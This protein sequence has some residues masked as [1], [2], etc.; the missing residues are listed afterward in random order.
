M[1]EALVIVTREGVEAA[2]V[3]AIVLAY[4]RKTGRAPLARWVYGGL[5]VALALSIA[6]AWLLPRLVASRVVNE[7]LV[8]GWLLLAGGLCVITLVVWLVRTGKRM[9]AEIDAGLERLARADRRF[10]WGLALFVTLLLVREGLETVLFLTAISFNTEGLQRLFGALAGLALAI[11]FGVLVV[12]GAL[13]VDLR[14]F[15]LATTGI[16]CVLAVQL[17]VGAYHEFAEAGWLPANRASMAIVGPVVRYDS[18]LFAVAI[19]ITF[20]LTYRSAAPAPA[21]PAA[22]QAHPAERRLAASRSRAEQRA[23]RAAAIAALSVVAV[24]LTGFVSQ[25]RVPPRA[26]GE[27]LV[28]HEGEVRVPVAGAE[29]AAVRFYRATAAGRTVRFFVARRSTGEPVAC[30]DA[31]LICGD[32][33]YYP[34]AAGMTCR[35]C[36]APIN[37]A[38]LGIG[39]G[40]NPI[41]LPSAARGGELV[42]DEAALAGAARYFPAAR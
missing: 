41:P 42:I 14:K 25:T 13:R 30:L 3:V 11:V 8:E 15:F 22:A 10:G 4:L 28:L 2:L 39:G 17:L 9:K 32:I 26:E 7:E 23:G 16:L 35:N 12:R 29:A 37:P 5:T 20:F 27:L 38:S 1:F 6:G 19:L 21:G 40:C 31:C 24:L 33:G 34:D 18:L 36:T